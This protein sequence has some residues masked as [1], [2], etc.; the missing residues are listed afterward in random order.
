LLSWVASH[1]RMIALIVLATAVLTI[2]V[3]AFQAAGIGYSLYRAGTPLQPVIM[4]WAVA[5][6][7]GFLAIG[8]WWAGRRRS[9]SFVA[10]AV[11]VASDRSFGIFLSHPLVLWLILLAGDGILARLVPTPWLTL[12]AYVLVVVGAVAVTELARRSPVSLLLTG[13]PWR[14]SKES[15]PT[16]GPE[17]VSTGA[18]SASPL[19]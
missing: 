3:F 1:R 2:A 15:Q 17:S 6:S 7:L 19:D 12:V 4:V 16:K 11:D 13:R 10:K 9:G 18:A 14:A 5:V 8:S